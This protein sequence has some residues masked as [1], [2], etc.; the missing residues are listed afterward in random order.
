M[1]LYSRCTNTLTTKVLPFIQC[2]QMLKVYLSA[3]VLVRVYNLQ[4]CH[5]L[6]TQWV[7][8]IKLIA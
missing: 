3:N 8:N 5:T 6:W 1:I 2:N 4:T 7:Y